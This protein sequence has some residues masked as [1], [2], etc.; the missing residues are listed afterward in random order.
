M[1]H[2]LRFPNG[3]SAE[4]FLQ[5]YWQQRPLLLRQALPGFAC[6]LEPD[7][8]AGLACEEGIESRLVLEKAGRTPWEIRHGPFDEDGFQPSAG[9]SLDPAGAG[10]GQAGILRWPNCWNT[11]AFC[12]TGGS[13]T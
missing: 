11:S 4:R 3:L 13:T 12:P 10:C 5:E 8:L 7:E 1:T 2:T 6:G 9:E